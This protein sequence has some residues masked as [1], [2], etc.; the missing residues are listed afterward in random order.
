MADAK[1][2]SH[3]EH[4]RLAHEKTLAIVKYHHLRRTG[5]IP[6]AEAFF[7]KNQHLIGKR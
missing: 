4:L 3:A 5:D 7:L 6:A 2:T 1:P